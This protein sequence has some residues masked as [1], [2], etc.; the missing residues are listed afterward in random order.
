MEQF[1]LRPSIMPNI[2]EVPEMR[3][4]PKIRVLLSGTVK[5]TGRLMRML[6]VVSEGFLE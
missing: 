4:L 5:N 2:L 6:A 3:F 1:T